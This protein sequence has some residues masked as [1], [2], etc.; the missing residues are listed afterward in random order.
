[1]VRAMLAVPPLAAEVP[2][3]SRR[4]LK[5]LLARADMVAEKSA[6]A[7]RQGCCSRRTWHAQTRG[8]EQRHAWEAAHV[9]SR[10][11]SDVTAVRAVATAVAAGASSW[12]LLPGEALWIGPV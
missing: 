12:L 1:M 11:V 9:T 7:L 2:R 5:G 10:D 6:R 3:A 8:S 4:L